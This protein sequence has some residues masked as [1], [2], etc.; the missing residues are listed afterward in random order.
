MIP[1]TQLEIEAFLN[2]VKYGSITK[3]AEV[4]YIS[5]PALSRRIKSL[6]NELQYEL[7]IRQKGI[8]NVILTPQGE[9]FIPIAEK[10]QQL[11]L[12]TKEIKTLPKNTVFHIAAIDS[13]NTYILPKVYK[14]FVEE[15][16]QIH[17]VIH[18]LHSDDCYKY[19]E[20]KIVNLG[21]ISDDMYSKDVKTIPIFSE[22][23][24]FIC[25]KQDNYPKFVHPS[26][27]DCKLEIRLPW[28]PEFDKW[29]NYWFGPLSKSLIIV[30]KM[31]LLDNFLQIKNSWAIVPLSIGYWLAQNN[32]N[33]EIHEIDDGPPER[34]YYYIQ[35]MDY[36][37]KYIDIFLHILQDHLNS[38]P[39]VV[40]LLKLT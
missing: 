9:A 21:F 7:F 36:H 40:C 37:S 5:Q 33:L 22:K 13:I 3:A 6:E 17:L 20:N 30:D 27:L 16:H 11:W 25:H 18:S 19:V 38:I 31:S 29:H 15:N 39:G 10:W 23:M 4:L 2:I 34:I 14:S 12:E 8:R 35:H 26:K 32:N 1:L 24:C 28:N